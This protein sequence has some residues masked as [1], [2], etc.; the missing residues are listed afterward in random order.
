LSSS[1]YKIL[2]VDKDASDIDI[3]KGY[4]RESLKHHPDKGGD[5]E[6]FKLVNEAFSV[7]SDPT[8]RRRFDMGADD[9]DS[10]MPDPFGGMGGGMGGFGGMGGMGGGGVEINLADILSGMGGGGGMGGHSFGGS[11]GGFGE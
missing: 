3:K 5:E 2:G 1:Y 10:D 7:L 8:K 4:K 9:P 11:Q 6:K